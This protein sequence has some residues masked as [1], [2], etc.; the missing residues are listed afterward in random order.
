MKKYIKIIATLV[1][2]VLLMI[3]L[4]VL[5]SEIWGMRQNRKAIEK[6]YE[7]M[8]NSGTAEDVTEEAADGWTE[9]YR[10]LAEENGDLFGWIHI[11]GTDID[12]PVMYSP[13]DPS[14]YLKHNFWKKWSDYGTPFLDGNCEPGV[15][16]N[17][18]IYGHNMKN[19]TMFA[20]LHEYE[21]EEFWKEHPYIQF[22][23]LTEQGT[24]EIFAVFH[25]DID[26]E[27]YFFNAHVNMGEMEVREFVDEASARQLYDADIEPEYGDQF[28]TLCTCDKTYRNGRFFVIAR[29]VAS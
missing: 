2:A 10:A 23:T 17:Y 11:A 8:E 18:V 16:N 19:G 24:Y 22:D 21:S 12:L 7:T 26:N 14:Y 5:A 15:S 1:L 9:R 28:L 13:D 29:K 6:V 4:C 20:Q 3:S 27:D 25:F